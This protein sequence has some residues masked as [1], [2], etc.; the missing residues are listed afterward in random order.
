MQR[1]ILAPIQ[2]LGAPTDTVPI[3]TSTNASRRPTSDSLVVPGTTM[4]VV[5]IAQFT[6]FSRRRNA[7]RVSNNSSKS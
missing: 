3:E 5:L 7:R 1:S 4:V 6:S 2:P